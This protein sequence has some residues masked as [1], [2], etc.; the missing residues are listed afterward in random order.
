[1]Q[2][3][4]TLVMTGMIIYLI[5]NHSLSSQRVNRPQATQ[6]S[7]EKAN[8][9]TKPESK[10]IDMNGNFIERTMSNVLHNVL[11]T[12]EGKIFFENLVQPMDKP[13]ASGASINLNGT[14]FINSLFKIH[15]FGEGSKGPAS[16]GHIVTIDYKILTTSNILIKEDSATIQLGAEKIAPGL[17]AIIVGMKQGQTRHAT[18]ATKYFTKDPK[19]NKSYFKVQALLKNIMPSNFAQDVKIFDDKITYKLP[20]VC[21]MRAN[22]DVRI[23]QLSSDEVIFDSVLNKS[24]INMKIGDLKYPMIFSHALH[25]KIPIGTR[26]VI[27]KGRHLKSYASEFSAIFPSRKI[28]ENEMYM[29][30][31]FNFNDEKN[32]N[33]N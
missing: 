12:E 19:H 17:D 14:D 7:N 5:F 30:E 8:N 2:K 6:G 11:K 21:G 4:L 28:P 25:N 22:Y 10:E 23:T 27:T 32:S 13:L 18:I 1:M 3:L 16:C 24:S 20:M 9:A 29:I 26:T 31:F 33:L 15:T